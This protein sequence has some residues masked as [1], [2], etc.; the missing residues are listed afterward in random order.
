MRRRLSNPVKIDT[1][2]LE[3]ASRCAE[4]KSAHYSW[5]MRLVAYAMLV[6]SVAIALCRKHPTA[7]PGA[8]PRLLLSVLSMSVLPLCRHG[9][10]EITCS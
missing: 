9:S 6:S 2:Q 7:D 5:I 8:L 10:A 4:K 3:K 1:T